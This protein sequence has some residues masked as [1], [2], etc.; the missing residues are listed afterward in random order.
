MESLKI[1][2]KLALRVIKALSRIY[3]NPK[4][5][6]KYKNVFQLL[7]AV[8]LS[9]QTT[10]ERVNKVTDLLFKKYPNPQKL[11]KACRED[12]EKIIRPVGYYKQKAKYII[13]TSKK[14]LKVKKVPS[15]M[16]ELIK[17]DG[18][19]RKTANIVL[20]F[21]YNKTEGVAVDTHC[22]RVSYRIGITTNR[23]SPLKI[24]KEL[25]QIIPKKYWGIYTNL[26]IAHGR[27]YCKARNPTCSIC[28][29][30]KICKMRL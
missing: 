22:S 17:L 5:K 11:A 25:M 1:R 16:Q 30:N 14:I 7:I 12:V 26:M 21:G 8:I 9:A 28:P 29:I 19:G 4:T 3:K 24:E 18:V 2:K 27:K 23:S 20:Y 10:D 15:T 6:L 13:N